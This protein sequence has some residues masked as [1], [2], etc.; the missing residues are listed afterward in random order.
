MQWPFNQYLVSRQHRIVYCP[1]PK[2]AC[3]SLKQWFFR[4]VGLRRPAFPDPHDYI[5]TNG[6]RL[7]IAATEETLHS[8][9]YFRFI[10][11]RDPCHRLVSAYVDILVKRGKSFW[12]VPAL[13]EKIQR[14]RGRAVDLDEGISFREFAEYVIDAPDRKLDEHWCPQTVF[15]G[16]LE[17][18]Y[19]GRYEHLQTDLLRVAEMAGLAHCPPLGRLNATSY[20]LRQAGTCAADERAGDLRRQAQMPHWQDFYDESLLGAIRDRY[21]ADYEL[22]ATTEPQR[23]AEPALV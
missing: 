15:M 1:V 19:V 21:A 22:L 10:F 3:S 23:E 20:V 4:L 16:S 6:M 11:L 8:P 2:V 12:A 17:F 18:A 14:Q 13:T 5:A 9:D 7:G